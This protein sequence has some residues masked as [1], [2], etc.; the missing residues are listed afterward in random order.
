M[1]TKSELSPLGTS[2]HSHTVVCTPH[3]LKQILGEPTHDTN[4]GEDKVNLEWICQTEDGQVFTIY[5]WKEYHS[6]NDNE[7][8]EWHIG[9]KSSKVTRKAQSELIEM[10]NQL[11]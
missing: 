4:T 11:N 1:I 5:D 9:G 10:L 8:I 7:E 2:Y 6:L 3:E